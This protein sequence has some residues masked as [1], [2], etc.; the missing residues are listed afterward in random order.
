MLK[1]T[2]ILP[3]G[4][5]KGVFQLAVLKGIF[6][7]FK[8]KN[9]D[10]EIKNIY[11]TSVGSIVSP[12]ILTNRIDMAIDYL[13][14]LKSIADISNK[15][16]F[17]SLPVIGNIFSYY[18]L[19]FNRSYFKGLDLSLLNKLEDELT[20]EELNNIYNK[21]HCCVFNIETGKEEYLSG[22]EWKL[23]IEASASL[24]LVYPP[25]K[26]EDKTYIDGGITE[27]VPLSQINITEINNDEDHYL[28]IV[29]FKKDITSIKK[30]NITKMNILEYW[31]R[32]IELSAENHV[33]K[34]YNDS[35][36]KFNDNKIQMISMETE[37]NNG[38]DFD[39]NKINQAM[40]EGYA[41][42]ITWASNILSN[43]KNNQ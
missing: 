20:H 14:N 25:V 18:N 8:T 12:F 7:E 28:L 13:S 21:L 38:L 43:A 33:I 24:W 35:I 32:M 39:K 9:I 6:E 22:K 36:I 40:Y 27:R 5:I 16:S 41:K 19:I 29:N 3:G 26:I 23:N 10:F 42:G 31:N 15:W 34:D 1:L 37:F 17:S 2:I 4:G 11:G 30:Q